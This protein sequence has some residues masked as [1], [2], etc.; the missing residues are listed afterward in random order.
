[1]EWKTDP[2][3]GYWF[4]YEVLVRQPLRHPDDI[5]LSILQPGQ[6]VCS[7]IGISHAAATHHPIARSIRVSLVRIEDR[8]LRPTDFNLEKTSDNFKQG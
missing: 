8:V 7:T 3:I 4:S 5:F 1:M 2:I 6:A